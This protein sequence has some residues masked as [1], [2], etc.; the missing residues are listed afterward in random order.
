MAKYLFQYR[1]TT[2]LYKFGPHQIC[3]FSDHRGG[4][5]SV[6]SPRVPPCS[7]RRFRHWC[8]AC[9]SNGWKSHQ[10]LYRLRWTRLNLTCLQCFNLSWP[11]IRSTPSI[12]TLTR[13]FCK[14]T[15][16]IFKRFAKRYVMY[17]MQFDFVM[18]LT[19]GH[20]H[21]S[22]WKYCAHLSTKKRSLG[23]P[24]LITW[25]E[26]RRDYF[27]FSTICRSHRFLIDRHQTF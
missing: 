18:D 7:S 20:S 11:S 24:V 1:S 10:W 9:L 19:F 12:T 26:L 6:D 22:H 3:K 13:A 2:Y 16:V 5:S 25:G 8:R 14:A 21:E 23:R 4:A 15:I 17:A 27:P